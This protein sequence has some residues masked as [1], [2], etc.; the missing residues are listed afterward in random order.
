MPTIQGGGF[1]IDRRSV[2]PQVKPALKPDPMVVSL[3]VVA[4]PKAS[5]TQNNRKSMKADKDIGVANNAQITY[6]PVQKSV[7]GEAPL[8]EKAEEISLS[9]YGLNFSGVP[10]EEDRKKE[11][12]L[13]ILKQPE[14]ESFI[15]AQIF[16]RS[17]PLRQK[18]KVYESH[19]HKDSMS[20][21]LSTSLHLAGVHVAADE[22]LT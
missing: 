18:L 4:T 11:N 3:A 13:S 6:S 14:P 5:P 12:V 21:T 10:N 19:S 9:A 2:S 1:V 20:G 8:I 17:K 16:Y 22:V 15:P 7:I